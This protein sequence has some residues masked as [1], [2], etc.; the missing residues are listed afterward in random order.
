MKKFVKLG[1]LVVAAAVVAFGIR[2]AYDLTDSP[3]VWHEVEPEV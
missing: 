1:A 3:V 2:T